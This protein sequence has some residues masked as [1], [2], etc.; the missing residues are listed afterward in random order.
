MLWEKINQFWLLERSDPCKTY[1]ALP[2]QWPLFKASESKLYRF[3]FMSGSNR[4]GKTNW[5]TTDCGLWLQGEHP[6]IRTAKRACGWMVCLT[7]DM[8]GNI[9]VPKLRTVLK[10]K[11]YAINHQ[12]KILIMTDGKGKGNRV[13]FKSNEQNLKTFEGASVQR[14]W[15]DEEIS[16]DRFNA[17][18]MR[19]ADSW[20]QI[21]I[22]ATLTTGL[23]YLWDDFIQPAMV[24]E[25]K[26][27]LVD[28]GGWQDNVILEKKNMDALRDQVAREDELL[29]RI[30]FDGEFLSLEGK[31][32]FDGRVLTDDL[33][34][35]V[36][37]LEQPWRN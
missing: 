36:T 17:I 1:I 6:F 32:V 20:T 16:Q 2:H 4:R 12:K 23:S 26:D 10:P 33:K 24:G 35:E 34:R 28:Y 37:A 7:D 25:R 5:L 29:A 11:T 30:R 14:V 31:C 18:C 19:T 3:L 13:V 9:I 21:L 22:A 27:C 15:V 8:W